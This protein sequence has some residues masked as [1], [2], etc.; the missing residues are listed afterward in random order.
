MVPLTASKNSNL[1]F[2]STFDRAVTWTE[3]L[4]VYLGKV[5]VKLITYDQMNLLT[6][7]NRVCSNVA[8][9]L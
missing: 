8:L 9:A 3:T 6:R 2:A 7:L 5:S 1:F 4:Q